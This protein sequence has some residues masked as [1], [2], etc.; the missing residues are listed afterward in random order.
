MCFLQ[1]STVTVLVGWLEGSLT[2]RTLRHWSPIVRNYSAKVFHFQ[3]E[4]SKVVILVMKSNYFKFLG[5][6][7]KSYIFIFI[8]CIFIW[9][10]EFQLIAY[11]CL[12]SWMLIYFS[13]LYNNNNHN[14]NSVADST[15]EL[16][17]ECVFLKL[18]AHVCVFYLEFFSNSY[19]VPMLVISSVVFSSSSWYFNHFSLILLLGNNALF[20]CSHKI[21]KKN[22]LSITSRGQQ[23]DRGKIYV[24]HFYIC[25][26]SFISNHFGLRLSLVFLRVNTHKLMELDFW[27][28]ITL[29]RWWPVWW[30]HMHMQQCL[31][32]VR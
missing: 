9:S 13:W 1:Y 4:I 21:D 16:Q 28:N 18:K 32:A 2:C 22:S 17:S 23:K 5:N 27:L 7:K 30:V 26:F 25:K 31:L 29:L 10:G 24:S 19:L 12:G 6:Y 14:H 15:C 20:H 8:L 11:A 3:Q